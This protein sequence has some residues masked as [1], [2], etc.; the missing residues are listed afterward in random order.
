MGRQAW[1]L[2]TW[3]S[4][5]AHQRSRTSWAVRFRQLFNVLPEALPQH[6]GGKLR[7]LATTG[8]KALDRSFRMCR[9]L[10]EAGYKDLV[11]QEWFGVFVPV[12]T[13]PEK[14]IVKL[15]SSI[16]AALKTKEVTEGLAKL[17]F[18]PAGQSASEFGKLMRAEIR[19]VGSPRS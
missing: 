15:D 1:S 12:K 11:A 13:S 6:K 18:E 4:R 8:G 10:V 5:A 16:R 19:S 17:S 2:P 3:P 14:T 9:P 7:V